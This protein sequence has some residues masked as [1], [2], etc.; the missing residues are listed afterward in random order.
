MLDNSKRC[1]A[2]VEHALADLK[3]IEIATGR[4]EAGILSEY[5]III[6]KVILTDLTHLNQKAIKRTDK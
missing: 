6:V 5:M 1:Q 3:C 2:G 4:C